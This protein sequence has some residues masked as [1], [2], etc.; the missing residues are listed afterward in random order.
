MPEKCHSYT[1]DFKLK[2]LEWYHSNGENKQLTSRVFNV[3]PKRITEWLIIEQQLRSKKD[4][5]GGKRRSSESTTWLKLQVDKLLVEWH[6]EKGAEGVK[7]T[8]NQLRSKA[9][10]LAIGLG[11]HNF[12]ASSS[13]IKQWKKRHEE[14]GEIEDDGSKSVHIV[15][16][17]PPLTDDDNYDND[18]DDCN[19]DDYNDDNDSDYDGELNEEVENDQEQVGEMNDDDG[20]HRKSGSESLKAPPSSLVSAGVSILVTPF[21]FKI[22]DLVTMHAAS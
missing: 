7:P 12:K 8:L 19:D 13:W 18:D 10:E 11:L 6:K 17:S 5:P 3:Q 9:L 15:T 20:P 2:L 21:N 16:I 22:E 14:S 4:S 1:L